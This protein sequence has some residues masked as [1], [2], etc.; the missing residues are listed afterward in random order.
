MNKLILR[1]ESSWTNRLVVDDF[2][3]PM[4]SATYLSGF[5]GRPS[6]YPK[7]N[8][9]N[10]FAFIQALNRLNPDMTY[11]VPENFDNTIIGVLAR[12][13]GEIR[14]VSD[15]D[16]D[17][18]AIRAF[19][20]IANK[21]S[22]LTIESLTNECISLK[23]CVPDPTLAGG[24][25]D[26]HN[27]FLGNKLIAKKIFGHYGASFEQIVHAVLNGGVQHEWY[28]ENPSDL[29]AE[30]LRLE[31]EQKDFKAANTQA[32]EDLSTALGKEASRLGYA[33]DLNQS[34]LNYSVSGVIAILE[35]LSLSQAETDLIGD[36]L[37]S[38]VPGFAS[39]SAKSPGK[40]TE[41]DFK[42]FFQPLG[43]KSKKKVTSFPFFVGDMWVYQYDAN[44]DP[45]SNPKKPNEFKK[46]KLGLGVLKK[47]GY[48][49]LLISD[50]DVFSELEEK[51]EAAGVNILSFGKKGIAYLESME[52]A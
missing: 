43:N 40:I 35:F 52:S 47:D 4:P 26:P 51:I 10:L 20:S 44:G 38:N 28:F 12:L 11:R 7:K 9:G 24:I 14:R 41:K 16:A 25:L 19:N 49:K 31:K 48:M 1:F 42:A 13:T 21:D 37:R 23:T 46:T 45:I 18:I 15:L 22:C 30:Y 50:D 17:H 33:I 5:S 3:R 8:S 39:L 2:Y 6:K 32:Y 34:G 27:P 36:Y 29:V